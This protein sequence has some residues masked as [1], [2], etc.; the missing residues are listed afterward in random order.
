MKR[1]G[2]TLVELLIVIAIIGALT[3]MMTLSAGTS[4]AKA[5]AASIISGFKMV[6]TAVIQYELASAD[7]GPT[8]GHF[9]D[10]ASKDYVGPESLGLLGKYVVTADDVTS[11]DWTATYSYGSNNTA[12]QTQLTNMAGSLGITT[13]EGNAIMRVR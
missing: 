8:V 1:K 3:A 11:N 7:Q 10:V 12:V 6:R 13:T 4:A 9:N 2:F 5:Q